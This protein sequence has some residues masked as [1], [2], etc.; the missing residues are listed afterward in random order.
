M[1]ETAEFSDSKEFKTMI[2]EIREG[3][4]RGLMLNGFRTKF[5]QDD[6]THISGKTRVNIFTLSEEDEDKFIFT[7]PEITE[8]YLEQKELIDVI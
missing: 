3:I 1:Y 4:T 2:A 6:K 8:I 7:F 5:K